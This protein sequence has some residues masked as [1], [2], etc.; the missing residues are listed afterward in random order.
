MIQCLFLFLFVIFF[1]TLDDATLPHHNYVEDKV[2]RDGNISLIFSL[3]E[4]V[5]ALAE[6][7]RLFQV[8]L[9]L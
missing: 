8:N 2:D 5:G 9:F 6:A 3:S 4:K 1:Q 7:L